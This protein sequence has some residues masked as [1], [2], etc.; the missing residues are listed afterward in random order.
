[1]TKNESS[2]FDFSAV[3]NDFVPHVHKKRG[4]RRNFSPLFVFPT[5]LGYRTGFAQSDLAEVLQKTGF[6]SLFAK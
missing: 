3:N 4:L 6:N 5:M 1:M 2:K